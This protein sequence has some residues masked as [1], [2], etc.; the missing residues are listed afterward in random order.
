MEDQ[1]DIF[2]MFRENQRKLDERPPHSAWRRLEQRLDSHKYRGRHSLYRTMAMVAAVVALVAVISLIT[3]LVEQ[4]PPDYIAAIEKAPEKMEDLTY[5]DANREGFKVIEYSRQYRDRMAIPLAEGSP[6]S[7]LVANTAPSEINPVGEA[8]SADGPKGFSLQSLKWL[9]GMWEGKHG[10]EK[11]VEHWSM[12]GPQTMLGTGSLIYKNDTIFTEK[13][14][15]RQ[16]GNLVFL[17][18]YLEENG[19]STQFRL[20]DSKQGKAVFVNEKPG[21]PQQIVFELTGKNDLTVILG[22]NQTNNLND[23]QMKYLSRRHNFM[24][25]QA[26]RRLKRVFGG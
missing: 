10:D 23:S 11:S 21:F 4:R 8:A 24:D 14:L 5:T 19:E 26:V 6:N 9:Q 3:V 20:E 25:Q 12:T 1:K 13:M 2:K 7:K 17:S 16:S 22:N 15:V 18:I